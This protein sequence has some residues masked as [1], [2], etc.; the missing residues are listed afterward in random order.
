MDGLE[1]AV[2]SV[3]AGGQRRVCAPGKWAVWRDGDQVKVE[4]KVK[5]A[6]Q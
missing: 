2:A 3:L 5:V 6:N 1:D 4:I